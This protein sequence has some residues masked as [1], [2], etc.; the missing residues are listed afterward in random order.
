MGVIDKKHV[1]IQAPSKAGSTF[2]NYKESHCI[3]LMTVVDAANKFLYIDVR[4]FGRQSDGVI[5]GN[6]TF[7]KA[8]ERNLLC[9][10][11]PVPLWGENDTKFPCNEAFPLKTVLLQPF[12]GR[13]LPIE[14]AVFN[15]RL[16]VNELQSNTHN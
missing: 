15:Y 16:V 10:P 6:S 3:V 9:L 12:P 7:G 4:D 13:F 11:S 1:I 5:C 8:L 14:E 2:Y